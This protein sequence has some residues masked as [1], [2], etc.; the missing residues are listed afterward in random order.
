MGE[1][2]TDELGYTS[3]TIQYNTVILPLT[4]SLEKKQSEQNKTMERRGG[5]KKTRIK[6][7]LY[8]LGSK[9]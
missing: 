5:D 6:L 2:K 8:N 4:V 7:T 1:L 9:T 3:Y